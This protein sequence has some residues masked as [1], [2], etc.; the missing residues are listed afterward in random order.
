MH[1]FGPIPVPARAA[2]AAYHWRAQ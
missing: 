2:G 1:R